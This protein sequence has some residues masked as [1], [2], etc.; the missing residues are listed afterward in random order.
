MS[1]DKLIEAARDA[2][3]SHGTAHKKICSAIE[4]AAHSCG[5]RDY[6]H[7]DVVAMR[8]EF[9]EACAKNGTTK[10]NGLSLFARAWDSL[11][12]T[13][14]LQQRPSKGKSR[15]KKEAAAETAPDADSNTE[16]SGASLTAE[17]VARI[18]AEAVAEFIATAGITAEL[19]ESAAE[20]WESLKGVNA[21]SAKDAIHVVRAL[22]N[23]IGQALIAAGVETDDSAKAKI[24]AGMQ[25]GQA[26][27][28]NDQSAAKPRKPLKPKPAAKKPQQAA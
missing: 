9:A 8:N 7:S 17:A 2:G 18:R 14:S 22:G 21:P 1:I 11:V 19:L 12:D 4:S 26:T 5:L 3:A 20:T 25:R 23:V 24:L 28:K 16:A 10:K 15:H 27:A 13:L 6:V